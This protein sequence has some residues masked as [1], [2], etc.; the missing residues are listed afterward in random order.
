MDSKGLSVVTEL[1]AHVDANVARD[2]AEQAAYARR[3]FDELGRDGGSIQAIGE[4]QYQKTRLS[5]LGRWTGDPWPQQTYGLD[6]ST[7]RP[8]EFNNGLIVDTAYAKLGVA[9][10]NADRTVEEQ[11]TVKTVVHLADDESTLHATEVEKDGV[12]GE[13]VR[14]PDIGRSSQLTKRVATAAQH[15]AESEHL[16]SCADAIDGVC[17]LDGAVYPLGVIY[18]LTLGDLGRPTPAGGWDKPTEI[19]RNYITVIDEQFEKD[20][21]VIGVVKTS[22]MDEVL[23]AL[24]RKLDANNVTADDGT[25]LDVPWTRDHQFVGEVLRD[26]SLDHL[27][28]TSW[29]EQTELTVNGHSVDVVGSVSDHLSHGRPEDYRRAFFYVRLPKSADVLRVEVPYLMVADEERRQQV[30]YKAL[31]EIAR[32]QDV[33]EAIKRADRI[34]RIT[35]RNR[36]TIREKITSSEYAHDYNWD[37]RWSD[38][39]DPEIDQ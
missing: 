37:G 16:R 38:I 24:E 19:V 20:L 10:P 34:A 2:E 14:F 35:N 22:T 29:F 8:L 28:Y 32:R 1:F 7:T 4:P 39:E 21:P 25:P 13:V 36:E 3:L 12:H 27:T 9:G 23:T 18:W 11:G 5:E 6:A 17:F 33:P 15:L 26:G 30:Q 31:K